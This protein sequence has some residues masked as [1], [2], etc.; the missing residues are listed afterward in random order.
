MSFWSNIP[1]NKK[2]F[3][4]PETA[5]EQM[6]NACE[7][8]VNCQWLEIGKSEEGRTIKGAVI[9][10]GPQKIS[11]IAGSHSDEPVGPE[12]LR[13]FISHIDI[14]EKTNPKLFDQFTFLIIPHINPDGEAQNWEWIDNW[15]DLESYMRHAFREL[16]GRDLEFGY[17][18]MRSENRSVSEI[19]REFAPI[20]LHM[21]LH[22]MAF[23]EGAML[24]IERHWIN[25][26]HQLQKDF[27]DFVSE[28]HL[29]L[30]DH[31]RGG[32]KGFEYIGPGFTTTPEG[33]AMKKYF[34]EKDDPDTAEK[35][36]LSSM[37]Y[38]RTLGK[39]PL[40][41][42][43]ELPLF[44]I[45]FADDRSSQKGLP[46]AYM[47]FKEKLPL[48]RARLDRNES[49]ENELESFNIEPLPLSTAMK[50]QFR[51][52]ELGLEVIHEE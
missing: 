34:M 18:D 51:T 48:M 41:L 8:S 2:S 14:I 21:S 39:N 42:V 40:C 31:D 13:T 20:D 22:G 52:I 23:S 49:I 5:S 16:P 43:T 32:E 10:N 1:L 7:H 45:S 37:E 4:D 12:T 24:L 6:E 29:P 50:I 15:P 3:I 28:Q 17:P 46:E 11:L 35:F 25:L 38:V 26:T 19:L 36:H 47:N 44:L 27:M 9:G 30:H 33:R